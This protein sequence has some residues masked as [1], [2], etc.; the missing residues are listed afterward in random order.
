MRKR[1]WSDEMIETLKELYPIET[2]ETVASRLNV[3]KSAVKIKATELGIEKGI[4][5][6]WLEK[7][8]A[9]RELHTTHSISE[10]SEK[11]GMAPRSVSR[12]ISYLGLK[13]EKGDERHIRSRIRKDLVKRERRRM[14]FGLQPLTNIK[15]VSNRKKIALRHKLKSQGCEVS[16]NA[17]VI[18]YPDNIDLRPEY[19][20]QSEKLGL[21]LLPIIAV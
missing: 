20:E 8:I 9:V 6:E 2:I 21:H 18:Y 5:R 1:I 15:V 16:R 10:I 4:K 19:F 11:V 3:G 14:I 13:R 12:I 17:T 7:A